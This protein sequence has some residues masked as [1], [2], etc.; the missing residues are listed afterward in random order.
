MREQLRHRLETLSEPGEL[1]AGG[2]LLY[3]AAP[4]QA[5]YLQ[6][7]WKPLWFGEETSPPAALDQVI[8]AIDLASIHGLEPEHYHRSR[9]ADLLDQLARAHP[10]QTDHRLQIDIEL[11]ASDALLTLAHHLAYGRIDPETNDPEWF[12]SRESPA[13][14]DKLAQAARDE[15]LTIRDI[16]TALLPTHSEYRALVE[17]LALQRQLAGNTDLMVIESG[18]LLRPGD[19]DPRVIIIRQRLIR[20]GDLESGTAD[21]WGQIS[22]HIDNHYDPKLEQ[23]VGRFQQRHGLDA[24]SVIGP[25]TLAALNVS[26]EARIEQLRANLERWRWLPHSLG[27]EYVIVNIAGFSMHVV[28]HGETVMRQRVMVGAPYRRTP[29]FTG[30]MTYLVLNP[31]WEVPHSLAVRDQLPRI[32]EDIGYLEDMGFALLQGW[33][34]NE[35]RID[36]H[37]VDWPA[38]SAGNFPYRLRQAPGPKNALG[39]VKFMFPNRHNVYLHDTPARGLFD[40]EDRALS[41]GCIRLEQPKDLIHWLLSERASIMTPEHIEAAVGSGRETTVRLDQPIPVHL[42][43]WTAWIDEHGQVQYRRDIYQR[44]RRLIEALDAPAPQT[45]I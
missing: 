1:V 8:H 42:L 33:G 25:R 5:L 3:A 18:S 13:L 32:R 31:S 27:D 4:L 19:L 11:L 22:D 38:L 9:L 34:V 12:V 21:A 43:Y 39:Q 40:Q 6:R 10:A 41:S 7:G 29:V 14:L 45:L 20:I 28:S 24:D 30:Q 36:P 37:E 35:Q 2:Q 23:A 44:D 15:K 26:P 16:L 17:R